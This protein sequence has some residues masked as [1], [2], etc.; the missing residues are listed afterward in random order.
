MYY[1]IVAVDPPYLVDRE[2]GEV[3]TA[4]VFTD[5]S[6]DIDQYTVIA[7]DNEGRDPSFTSTAVL[8]VRNSIDQ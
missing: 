3:T 8:T 1:E 7:Y 4:D 6:G 5:R 2:T